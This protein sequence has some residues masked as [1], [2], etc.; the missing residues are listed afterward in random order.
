MNLRRRIAAG[1]VVTAACAALLLRCGPPVSG[2]DKK[3]PPPA[4]KAAE[5]RYVFAMQAAAW[6]KVFDWL[7]AETGQPVVAEQV[8]TGTFTFLPPGGKTP[9]TFTLGEIIDLVN[10]ALLVKKHILVR[11]ERSLQ[12][13]PA[14]EKFDA[15][16]APLVEAG[17]LPRHGRTAIVRVM[18][19]LPGLEAKEALAAVKKLLGPFGDAQPAGDRLLVRD[20]VGNLRQ[21]SRVLQAI[22]AQSAVSSPRQARLPLNIE[23]I[24]LTTLEAPRAVDMLRALLGDG[25]PT[26][27]ADTARN[28]VL[29]RGSKEQV[30]EVRSALE[31]LGETAA[32]ASG[33][34]VITLQRGDAATLAEALAN[35]LK[36]LRNNPVR[37]IVPG[38]PEPAP[39]PPAPGKDGP[40]A[41]KPG[42]KPISLTGM[43]RTLIVSS[44][45]PQ[46]LALVQALVRL[47][48]TDR[49]GPLEVI[50]LKHGNAALVA[51][52]LDQ[53]INGRGPERAR[54][55]A[56]RAGNALLV[57]A[58]PLDMLTVR[59]LLARS[60][61]VESE[62]GA[63]PRTY[64]LGPLRH[65][66]AADI[67]LVL[68]QLY[69][70]EGKPA[71]TVAVDPRGNALL[72]RGSPAVYQD[73]RKLVMQ[74][75][76]KS[77]K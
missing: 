64:F 35:T 2:D 14:D 26:L 68:R 17:D 22:P 23:A 25:G 16:L 6:K 38:K 36:N 39:K 52:V 29:V 43:G 54:I 30:K 3:A 47:Y 71:V 8:P 58:T 37:V 40:A 10:D 48:S 33:V 56:D 53:A 41:K 55:V 75:D 76:V 72:L 34:R 27:V 77:E 65:V 61:D 63:G 32:P 7:T 51:R 62:H 45:D 42:E 66:R 1:A 60:L 11:R 19:P 21:I 5:K 24:P 44:D 9:R 4:G 15:A 20:T 74:L 49:P 69:Q 59:R 57:K 12:L 31:A 73:A 28:V 70:G 67:A 46:A 50:P 18:L 13:V